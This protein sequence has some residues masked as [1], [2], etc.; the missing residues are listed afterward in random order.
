M[1]R[2]SI[3]LAMQDNCFPK[4]KSDIVFMKLFKRTITRQSY[5]FST[6][7]FGESLLVC[8]SILGKLTLSYVQSLTE[9]RELS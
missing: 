8:F 7:C 6:D 3:E 5:P 4:E 9:R 1:R 2:L